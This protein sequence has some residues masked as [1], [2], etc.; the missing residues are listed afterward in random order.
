MRQTCWCIVLSVSSIYVSACTGGGSGGGSGGVGGS[1]GGSGGTGAT[2]SALAPAPNAFRL[3]AQNGEIIWTDDDD[4]ANVKKVSG[5]GGP[6]ALLAMRM[7]VPLNVVVHDQKVYWIEEKPLSGFGERWLKKV[8]PDETV[9]ILAEGS[10]CVFGNTSDL[11]VDATNVYWATS[12]CSPNTSTIEAISLADGLPTTLATINGTVSALSSDGTHLYWEE[13]VVT[14]GSAKSVMR[15]PKAGGSP[16]TLATGSFEQFRGGLAILNGQVFF[17]DSHFIGYTIR[18]VPSAGGA[19]TTLIDVPMDGP[20]RGIT[21][22]DV[23]VYWSDKTSINALPVNGGSRS[24]LASGQNQPLSIILNSDSVFWVETL[25]CTS[26]QTG[27][28]KKVPVGGGIVEIVLDNLAAPGGSLTIDGTDVFWTEGGPLLGREGLG[29]LARASLNGG[30]ITTVASGIF[31]PKPSFRADDQFIYIADV[32]TIKKLPINGGFPERLHSIALSQQVFGMVNSMAVDDAFVYWSE[33]TSDVIRRTP[34]AGGA[35]T[36]IFVRPNVVTGPP[37]SLT[38]ADGFLYWLDVQGIVRMPSA[39]G[40]VATVSSAAG[41]LIV[42]Q[43]YVYFVQ[44]GPAL[45]NIKKVSVNGGLV[46]TLVPGAAAGAFTQD[47]SHIYWTS[48]TEVGKVPKN[49]GS[50]SVYEQIVKDSGG[51]IAVDDTSVYWMRDDVLWKA[52]PK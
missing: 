7:G 16:Q 32:S 6:I 2:I 43:D 18:K 22:D 14:I 27:R 4:V 17:S 20:V 13:G 11:V 5:S 41:S 21:A 52:T 24:V 26:Q 39:G 28:I 46:T 25:C 33:S 49:G 10:G 45:S 15:L 35:V 37:A 47:D 51:G 44:G 38:V 34:K 23:N 31:N 9:T 1:G 42:D 3:Q 48:Q 12:T 19:L 8:S 36:T 30:A 40:S 50:V 29:R